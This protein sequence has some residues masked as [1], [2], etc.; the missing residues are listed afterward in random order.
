MT[1]RSFLLRSAAVLTG[2]GTV[3]LV[4]WGVLPPR[5]RL[6][7]AS[8]LPVR[9]G[10][11]ALNGWVRIQS[12]GSAVLIMPR[13]EMG[14][15]VYTGL[16][17]LL[18][19]ELDLP[20][21]RITLE[22][23]SDEAIYGNVAMLTG[24]L[25]FHPLER[26]AEP[27][28][29]LI[30]ASEWLVTKL[31]REL[32]VNVTGGSSSMADGWEIIRLAG[33][34]ARAA[35]MSAAA[36]RLNAPLTVLSTENGQVIHADG[37]K[38]SYGE[39]AQAAAGVTLE[40]DIAPKPRANW[41]LIGQPVARVDIPAKVNG[42]ARFGIDVRLPGMLFAAVSLCPTLGGRLISVETEALLLMPGVT[43]VVPLAPL[44]GTSGGFAVV[45]R[46]TWHAQQACLAANVKWDHGPH[47]ALATASIMSDLDRALRDE[48]GFTFYSRGDVEQALE[49]APNK[50]EATYQVPH[51]AHAALEPMNAT[52]WFHDGLLEVW[53]PTQIPGLAARAA[54]DVAGLPTQQVKLHVT[55]LGGGFGRRLESDFVAQA[56]KVAMLNPGVPVQTVWS[57]EQDMTHDFYRPAQVVKLQAGVSAAGKLQALKIRSAGDSIVDHWISRTLGLPGGL[58]DK[59]TAEGLFDQAYG[60][61]H[62]SITHVKSHSGVPIGFWRAVGH[63]HAA[64]VI[65]SFIDELADALAIDPLTFRLSL[66]AAAPRHRAVLELAADKSGWG[67]PLPVGRARGVALHESFGSVVA[68]VAELSI[69]D[70]HPRVHQVTCAIDCGTA[71]NPR[72]IA[73]QMESGVVFGLTAA[74]YGRIDIADGQVRQQ[75]FPDY[76]LLKLLEAPVV[77]THIVPSARAPSGVGEPGLPPIAPAVAN[78]LFSLTAIRARRLPLRVS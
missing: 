35:L 36:D 53:A 55:L 41:R 47:H 34:T 11:M 68:Q 32:G 50:L 74:L 5:S 33:A 45:A 27:A 76:P 65:E 64:F 10:S 17:T 62:Q 69:I 26:D 67:T 40:I 44:G 15:G 7:S 38:L 18:A 16:S 52:A 46:H 51:L 59:T 12:D 14:Q 30:R 71:V 60:I 13:V 43:A 61:E 6:G 28:S 37:R 31:G 42:S 77:S 22:Q 48:S 39:L 21:D 72:T 24:S 66:L 57:R 25:P 2:T 78:A 75:N 54:A 1:R 8:G 58:P 49:Q 29:M 3:L 20:L 9:E 4:G 73:Q 63:S 70:G 19:E 56:A 23:A